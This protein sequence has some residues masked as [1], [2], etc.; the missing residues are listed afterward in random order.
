MSGRFELR[1]A[2]SLFAELDAEL[3]AGPRDSLESER[4]GFLLCGVARLTD[5]SALLARAWRPIPVESRVTEP[6]YGLAW[7]AEFNAVILDEADALHAVPVLVHRH[8]SGRDARLSRRDRRMGDP[9]IA[10]M[11]RLARGRLAA[12]VVL[13]DST[14]AGILWRSGTAEAA[15]GEARIVGTPI[16]GISPTSEPVARSRRRLHRQS[17]AIGPAS[18]AALSRAKVA[19]VG[20]SGGGSHVVQQLAHQGIGTLIVIDDDIVEE[21]NRG[22]L[23]GSHHDD[24]GRLKADVMERLIHSVDP[25]TKVLAVPCRSSHPDGIAALRE[26]DVIVTCVDRFDVRAEIDTLARRNLIPVIDIGMTLE[27]D[28]ERL[29]QANGQVVLALPGAPCLRCTPLLSDAVLEAEARTA[30]PG[31]DR[32]PDAPGQPQVVS[33]NGLLAS[34]A[35]NLVLALVTGYLPADLLSNGGWWQ[36][37]AIQGQLDFTALSVRRPRCPGCAEEGHG[38]PWFA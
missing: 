38:D 1:I 2:D 34:Q 4:A 6:G 24:D 8:A 35:A 3:R 7:N 22:R 30:P 25:T 23:V 21:E 17:L 33:M 16:R 14:A 13:D 20:L 12:S 26:A 15:L 11:S 37:D 36:Y 19:I 28:G 9:L 32:N 27:S 18:D 5:R 31:Y 10:S 29:R